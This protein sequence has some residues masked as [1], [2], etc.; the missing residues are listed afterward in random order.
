MS[1]IRCQMSDFK[2]PNPAQNLT[3]FDKPPISFEVLARDGEARAG[4]LTTRRGIIRDTRLHACWHRGNSKRNA[5]RS[6][7]RRTRRA[8]H[9]CQHLSSLAAARRGRNTKVRRAAS[10]LRMATSAA[11]RFRG[12]SGLEFGPCERLPRRA[13]ASVRISAA[14]PASCRRRSRW[15]FRQRSVQRS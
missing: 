2:T 12:L 14:N 15:R 5:L 8:D 7:G 11:Y 9:S 13:L 3:M 1:D 10:L 4:I 6:S